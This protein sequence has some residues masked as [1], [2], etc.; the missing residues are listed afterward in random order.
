MDAVFYFSFYEPDKGDNEPSVRHLGFCIGNA[1]RPW[2]EIA[3]G[4]Y[5]CEDQ[6][7]QTYGAHNWMNGPSNGVNLFGYESYEVNA[8]HHDEL[9]EQWRQA[10]LRISPGCVVSGVLDLDLNAVGAAPSKIVQHAKD[11]YEQQQ[12]E[13]LR[14]TLST[15]IT[16]SAFPAAVKKI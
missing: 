16:T 12:A 10:F 4:V 13:L 5:E 9:M 6:L 2:N 11:L 1:T 14:D 15:N 3:E 7:E 8:A